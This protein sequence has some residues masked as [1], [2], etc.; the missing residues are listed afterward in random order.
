MTIEEK[1]DLMVESLQGMER[2]LE[3]L[4]DRPTGSSNKRM[5]QPPG[6]FK[7]PPKRQHSPGRTDVLVSRF[8]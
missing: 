2:R 3:R 8:S 7:S 6:P 4:K 1:L 5:R